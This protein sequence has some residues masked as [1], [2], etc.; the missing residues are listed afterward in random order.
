VI[1]GGVTQIGAGQLVEGYD[2]EW[3]LTTSWILSVPFDFLL[4]RT[5]Q[6]FSE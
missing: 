1:V 4:C 6:A 3:L 2:T 5:S